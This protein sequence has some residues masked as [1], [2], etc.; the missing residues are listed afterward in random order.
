MTED[1]GGTMP[2]YCVVNKDTGESRDI[3]LSIGKRKE[4]FERDEHHN[5]YFSKENNEVFAI[6]GNISVPGTAK[7]PF[8]TRKFGDKFTTPNFNNQKWI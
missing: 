3:L 7:L 2:L 1:D 4:F 8:A 6:N 5:T